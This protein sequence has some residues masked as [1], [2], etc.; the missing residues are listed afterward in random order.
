MKTLIDCD[1][2]FEMLTRAPFPSGGAGDDDVERHLA[3]CHECRQLAEAL[4]PAVGLF[5]ESL[6]EQ[7][8]L[9]VYSGRAG[10]AAMAFRSARVGPASARW[11]LVAVAMGLLAV[12]GLALGRRPAAPHVGRP[13][14]S[15]MTAA[16]DVWLSAIDA[17]QLPEDCRPV[18]SRSSLTAL[19]E[20]CCTRC[21]RAESEV[22]ARHHAL[23]T[24]LT[25]CLVC[26][27]ERP[28]RTGSSGRTGAP[29]RN[30]SL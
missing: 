12:C 9:P 22:V 20:R 4:R 28:A 13:L 7:D 8:E 27:D 10:S 30:Y 1:E 11:W 2:V 24:A 26:H 3:S 16:A 21:H 25:A 19:A 5:H 15:D 29:S 14:L 6:V 23:A 17:L 18:S